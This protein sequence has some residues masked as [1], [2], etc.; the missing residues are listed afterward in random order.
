MKGT[1]WVGVQNKTITTLR[2]LVSGACPLE[3]TVSRSNPKLARVGHY[4]I[5]QV[6]RELTKSTHIPVTYIRKVKY[7]I[8]IVDCNE[9]RLI[10]TYV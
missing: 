8:F 2:R 3:K 5:S 10:V 7:A 6:Q 9:C 1:Q 4:P